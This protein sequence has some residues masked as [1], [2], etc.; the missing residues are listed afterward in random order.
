MGYQP[1]AGNDSQKIFTKE[2][3][4][5]FFK[6]NC[7]KPEEVAIGMEVE[8]HGVHTKTHKPV[9]YLEQNGVRKI[10][11]KL[12]QELDWKIE[13]EE[14]KYIVSMNRGG[15]HFNLELSEAMTELSGR[16]H[17]S[18]HDLAREMRLH[19]QELSEISNLFDVLWFGIGY[20]PFALDDEIRLVPIQRYNVLDED[21][22][23][24]SHHSYEKQ[25]HN[26]ASVQANIDYIS[27]SDMQRKFSLLLRLAPFLS[28]MYAHSPLRTGK[29]TGFVSYRTHILQHMDRRRHGIRKLFFDPEFN[30]KKWINFCARI[31]MIAIFREG[32]W[33]PIPRMTFNQFLKR[34]FEGHMPMLSDW[35]LHLSYIY[36]DVRIRGFMELRVIDSLPPFMVPSVQA[37]VK[38]FVYHEEGPRFMHDLTKDWSFNDFVSV[39]R[40][41]AREGMDAKMHGKKLLDYCKEI[42]SIASAN[43]KSFQLMNEKRED[44]SIHLEPLKDFV[45]VKEK[46]PG[47]FVA[48]NWEGEW[49]KNPEKLIAWCSLMSHP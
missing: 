35:I 26:N 30:F 7:K 21:T 15:T 22:K 13:H 14:G 2:D 29:N 46:S 5:S 33:I 11:E 1:A 36:T 42:V 6:G 10:Q 9:T 38:A 32:H 44:E 23:R 28:A 34:G 37:M 20:Q 45:F 47:R 25:A 4:L 8:K 39:Y 18:I 12:I 43:L 40:G 17:P 3:L 31:P 24:R 48:E 49:N 16:T 19:Q 27:E 41:I